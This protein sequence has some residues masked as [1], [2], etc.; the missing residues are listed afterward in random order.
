MKKILLTLFLIAPLSLLAQVSGTIQGIIIEDETNDP[1]PFVTVALT[2]E[3][4]NAPT[5]GSS[6]GEEGTFRLNN[7]KAG[8]YTI[9]ISFVGYLDE[10]RNIS[11]TSGKSNINVGP[12]L[13]QKSFLSAF[14]PM[15][16]TYS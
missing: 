4:S 3:G 9:T 16:K 14:I 15:L 7:V 1:L 2:P 5:A 11:I 10:S 8:K 12:V 6:T 13:L